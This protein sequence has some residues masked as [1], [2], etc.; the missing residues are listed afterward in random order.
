MDW[1]IT[2]SNLLSAQ[3]IDRQGNKLLVGNGYIGY[4][5]TLEE[6]T[7][8]QKTATIVSGLYDQVGDQWREPVNLPNGCFVQVFHQGVLLHVLGGRSPGSKVM[9]HTHS[10]IAAQIGKVDW[11]YKY[12]MKTAT[13]DLTGEGKQYVGPLYI[14]GTHPAGNGGAW[15]AAVFGLCGIQGAG[16]TLKIQPHLPSHWKKVILSLV[17]R[18]QKL[19][20]TL[21]SGS[22]TVQ[23]VPALTSSLSVSVGDRTLPLPQAGEISLPVGKN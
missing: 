23:P 6:F 21:T 22:V 18:G 2:E 16:E 14:G 4:R 17:F 20:I 11:A 15:M 1:I 8:D 10:L 3:D 7:K 12:F 9:E 19:K 13:I 5:G